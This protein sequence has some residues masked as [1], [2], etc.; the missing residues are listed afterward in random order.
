MFSQNSYVGALTPSV[1][2]FG[3]MTYKEVIKDHEIIRVGLCRI[4]LV[5]L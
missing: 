4:R 2:R 5:S 3:N 1:T